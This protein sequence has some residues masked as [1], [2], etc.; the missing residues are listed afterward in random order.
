MTHIGHVIS[1]FTPA[2]ETAPRSATV[3]VAE[4]ESEVDAP[5]LVAALEA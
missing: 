3:P 4:Q 5:V 2:S 1:T